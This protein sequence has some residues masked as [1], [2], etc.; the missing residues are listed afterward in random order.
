MNKFKRLITVTALITAILAISIPLATGSHKILAKESKSSPM[1][2]TQMT[3]DAK[4]LP[5]LN[6][7]EPY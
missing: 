2:T 7:A 3:L 5:V 1:D 4:N 6:V